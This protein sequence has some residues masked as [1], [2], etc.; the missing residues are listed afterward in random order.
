MEDDSDAEPM[1][2]IVQGL[3]AAEVDN[4]AALPWKDPVIGP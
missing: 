4:G 1:H 3:D 2:M